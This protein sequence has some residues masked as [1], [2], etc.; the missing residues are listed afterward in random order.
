MMTLRA[1]GNVDF[2]DMGA[3]LGASQAGV[4][5]TFS[6]EAIITP[7]IDMSK[8][9]LSILNTAQAFS[10]FAAGGVTDGFVALE[11]RVNSVFVDLFRI[12]RVGATG[13]LTGTTPINSILTG[14]LDRLR[15]R[16]TVTAGAGTYTCSFDIG[17][18]FCIGSR[19]KIISAS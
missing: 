10:F 9:P 15:A 7:I 13:V 12:D 16:A 6:S 4:G 1:D 14:I 19:L 2:L 3:A 5:T 17:F 18:L 8:Y 11:G